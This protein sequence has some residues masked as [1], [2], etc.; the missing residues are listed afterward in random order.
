MLHT[1]FSIF[2]LVF[3]FQNPKTRE[4]NRKVRPENCGVSL[5]PL[6]AQVVAIEHH[7]GW[8][9]TFS[10]MVVALGGVYAETYDDAV[11]VSASHTHHPIAQLSNFFP[12]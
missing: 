11:F 9:G 2:L 6:H 3:L 5:F 7:G 1:I 4:K 8:T 12:L 10:R